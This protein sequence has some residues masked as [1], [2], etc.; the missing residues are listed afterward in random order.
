[1]RK[2]G[3][4]GYHPKSCFILSVSPDLHEIR[5]PALEVTRPNRE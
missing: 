5:P 1:M 2:L 4:K 3:W